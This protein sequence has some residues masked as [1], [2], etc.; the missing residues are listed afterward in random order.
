[1]VGLRLGVR[2]TVAALPGAGPGP[3][4]DSG[5]RGSRD[6]LTI[7]PGRPAGA[8]FKFTVSDRPSHESVPWASLTV[9]E[10][11]STSD[12]DIVTDSDRDSCSDSVRRSSPSEAPG[13]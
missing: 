13:P 1:M 2:V 7:R 3:D 10:Y 12:S 11:Q 9:A 5:D 8:L 4:S 6:G